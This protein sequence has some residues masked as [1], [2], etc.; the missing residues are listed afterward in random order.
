M[1]AP[2]SNDLRMKVIQAINK[3][4]QTKKEIAA[5][6]NVSRYFIYTL[7]K[8]YK[9]TGSV[10]PKPMG[11]HIKPKITPDGET[12]ILEWLDNQSDLTL[13]ELCDKYEAHFN[14]KVGKSSMD[15]ALKRMKVTFKKKVHMIPKKKALKLKN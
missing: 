6:F 15:R 5:T 10:Q 14:I 7:L 3:N 8:R 13:H 1:P 11:S 2:Y 4:Q 12:H 9:T